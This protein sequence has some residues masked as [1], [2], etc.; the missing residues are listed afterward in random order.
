MNGLVSAEAVGM[1]LFKRQDVAARI[2][3][4]V[5]RETT[6]RVLSV[7]VTELARKRLVSWK[8]VPVEFGGRWPTLGDMSP[9]SGAKVHL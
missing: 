4:D 6:T 1:T 8:R 9:R 7:E 2:S 3:G 5:A